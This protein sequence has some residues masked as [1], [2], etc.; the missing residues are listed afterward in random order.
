M[1]MERNVTKVEQASISH[2]PETSALNHTNTEPVPLYEHDSSTTVGT[3]SSTSPS[4]DIFNT[5]I[6]TLED[7][8]CVVSILHDWAIQV[9][10]EVYGEYLNF[11]CF[12]YQQ[13]EDAQLGL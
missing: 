7:M 11:H 3:F 1:M 12:V 5:L 6:S 8:R 2:Q 9:E 10:T 4:I 13:Q